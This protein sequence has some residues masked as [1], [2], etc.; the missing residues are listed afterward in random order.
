[1]GFFMNLRIFKSF[2]LVRAKVKNICC[3][4][5]YYE[6]GMKACN[7]SRSVNLLCI[8]I[9]EFEQVYT[10]WNVEILLFNSPVRV[11]LK[12]ICSI[13]VK[14]TLTGLLKSNIPT[15]QTVYTCSKS[16]INTL[17]SLRWE[18]T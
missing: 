4:S 15:F 3:V 18:W 16:S 12:Q 6:N 14:P 17:D 13:S 11:S 5:I 2:N 7:L 10:V 9:D 1:M 8:F